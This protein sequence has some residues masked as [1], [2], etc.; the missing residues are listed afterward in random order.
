MRISL[1]PAF[2]LHQRAYR[3]TSLLLDVF[4]RD[5]G[6]VS[7]IARGVRK[8]NSRWRSLLQPFIPLLISWQ[9]KTELMTLNGVEPTGGLLAPQKNALLSGFYLNELLVRLLHKH[10]P[11]PKLYDCYH[12]TLQALA[13]RPLESTLRLFEKN[14]LEE[15]GYGLQFG[16]TIEVE[17]YY[18]YHPEEG[19][20]P[21]IEQDMI[22]SKRVFSGKS[23]QAFAAEIFEDE[24]CLKDAKR[25]IR[26]ALRPLLG[27]QPL[28][29]R[30]LFI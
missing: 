22:V 25:L 11:H 24:T 20:K 19:F 29:S 3:E 30:Q 13:S 12:Q 5:H 6:R 7:L 16:H 17:Q 23:L 9:G 18:H 14:L 21:C 4:S 28:Y 1:Q 8:A 27:E 26:L 15:I 2:V 10:D